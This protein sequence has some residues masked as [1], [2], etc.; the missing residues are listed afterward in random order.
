VVDGSSEIECGIQCP[1]QSGRRALLK[2][3]DKLRSADILSLVRLTYF[4]CRRS[5]AVRFMHD[6]V[7]G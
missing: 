3:L 7:E 2:F 1:L 6:C 5:N 4:G